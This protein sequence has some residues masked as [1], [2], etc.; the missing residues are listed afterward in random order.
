MSDNDWEERMLKEK[1]LLI[2]DPKKLTKN[3]EL[4]EKIEKIQKQVAPTVK[5]TQ[6]IQKESKI[7]L[8]IDAKRIVV[9]SIQMIKGYL[10]MEKMK[11]KTPEQKH[12]DAMLAHDMKVIERQK[13]RMK[14]IGVIFN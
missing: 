5:E 7:K 13:Q 1:H 11:Q 12:Q 9:M 10:A 3:P 8:P 6:K 14:D 4:Q 2:T